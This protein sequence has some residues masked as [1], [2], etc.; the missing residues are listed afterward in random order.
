MKIKSYL[1]TALF[2]V[3]LISCSKDD[4]NTTDTASESGVLSFNSDK[5]MQDKIAEIEAF[6]STE[7]QQ[8]LQQILRRNNLS[9]PTLADSKNASSKQLTEADKAE[10]L[11][12]VKFYHQEKLKSIYAERARFGFTSIQSIADEINSLKLINSA[13]SNQLYD[14]YKSLLTKNEYEISTI[15]DKN[16]SIVTN[17]KGELFLKSKDISKKYL[18]NNTNAKATF[19]G[20]LYTKQGVVTIGH[21]GFIQI[22]HH[23]YIRRTEGKVYMGD[24]FNPETQQMEPMYR[25]DLVDTPSN[26]LACYVFSNVGYVSY[27]CYFFTN[28]NSFATF[29]GNAG[30][31]MNN[32]TVPFPVGTGKEI[33]FY[34]TGTYY[35]NQ[36]NITGSVSGNFAVPVAGTSNFLWVSGS[37]TF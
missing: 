30:V 25:Y 36:P 28:A 22:T 2:A 29:N 14:S 4:A 8:I 32:Q 18:I 31:S 21:N 27:P 37:K 20:N 15:F 13:K 6:K 16:I 3:T 26:K 17:K 1:L 35:A 33:D 24:F 10:V 23:S 7:E 19:I 34:G 5:E 11:E 9:A 12:E